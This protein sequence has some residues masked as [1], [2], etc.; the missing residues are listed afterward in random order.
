MNLPKSV[1]S[2]AK[3][4]KKDLAITITNEAGKV[5]YSWNFAGETL[6]KSNKKVTDMNTAILFGKIVDNSKVNE[7]LQQYISSSTRKQGIILDFKHSGILP[8]VASI[9]VYVG[10]SKG[11]EAG[12][13]VYLYYYN[14]KASTGSKLKNKARLE[15]GSKV[16]Y[17]VDKDGYV[18]IDI[19]HCSSYV[20]LPS[21]ANTKVVATLFEQIQTISKK[22]ISVKKTANLGIKLPIEAE[23]A[24]VVYTS[25]KKSV[26]T[27][28]QT[29]KVTGV[30]A[31]K[32]TIIAKVT[33]N[34]VTKS[35]KTT[36]TVK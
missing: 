18:T 9:R 8:S 25:S 10:D 20:L 11:M 28:S 30:K 3:T 22:A 1:I 5:M 34:G 17:T 16:V 26:A 21:K 24:K 27:V 19:R 23:D 4:S 7:S 33:M 6:N 36:V 29:G 31:G 32:A 14:E 35:Y 13:K 15:E 2:K 12:K